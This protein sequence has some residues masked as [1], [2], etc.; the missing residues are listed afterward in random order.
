MCGVFDSRPGS[1]VG[2]ADAG[3]ISFPEPNIVN[4]FSAGTAFFF[5]VFS[6]GGVLTKGRPVQWHGGGLS[7]FSCLSTVGRKRRYRVTAVAT[8][9]SRT[10]TQK[11]S[12]RK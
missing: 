11:I 3:G 10:F 6:R 1:G 4:I 2:R 8:A 9:M 7:F 12:T 5:N